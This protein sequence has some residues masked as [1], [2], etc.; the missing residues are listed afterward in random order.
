MFGTN[1]RTCFGGEAATL[2]FGVKETRAVNYSIDQA[3]NR[4]GETYR[5]QA[6]WRNM[7]PETLT[8]PDGGLVVR[9]MRGNSVKDGDEPELETEEDTGN[10]NGSR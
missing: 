6:V 1:L 5:L 4:S 8:L 3:F 7:R 10:S 9:A 2:G